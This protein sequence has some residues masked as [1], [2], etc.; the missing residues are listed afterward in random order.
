MNSEYMIKQIAD[1]WELPV[2]QVALI[3]STIK[4]YSQEVKDENIQLLVETYTEEEMN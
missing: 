1:E 3:W 2:P 4:W